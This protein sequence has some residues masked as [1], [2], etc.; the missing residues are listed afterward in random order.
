MHG[1]GRARFMINRSG[2]PL[3]LP[4]GA[5]RRSAQGFTDR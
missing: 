1:G 5:V 4:S 2:H 3:E